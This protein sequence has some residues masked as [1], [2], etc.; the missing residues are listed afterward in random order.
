V[1]ATNFKKSVGG[2]RSS[3]LHM[4]GGLRGVKT[5]AGWLIGPL[6]GEHPELRCMGPVPDTEVVALC[7]KL[8]VILFGADDVT[9]VDPQL[10]SRVWTSFT[11]RPPLAEQPAHTWAWVAHSA[12]MAGDDDYA[13]LARNV[14]FTLRAAGIRLRDASDEYHVQLVAALH[15][16]RK[17]GRFQNIPMDDLHLAFHSLLTELASARDYLAMIAAKQAGT[18]FKMWGPWIDKVRQRAADKPIPAALLEATSEPDPWLND[19]GKYRNAFVHKEPLGVNEHARW[20]VL[21]ERQTAFGTIRLV[22]MQVAARKGSSETCEALSR[23]VSL[24]MKMCRLADF[25]A[26]HAR[27]APVIPNVTNS[28]VV[29]ANLPSLVCGS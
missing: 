29:F 6:P 12:R 11:G 8:G 22:E 25:A 2:R 18:N 4:T 21:V 15:S 5:N 28:E 19:L 14:A 20:L 1:K 26:K 13:A 9:E 27:Y 7:D 16:K 24:H 17:I 3:F 10:P 23:F